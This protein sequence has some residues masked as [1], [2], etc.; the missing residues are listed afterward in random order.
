MN[1]IVKLANAIYSLGL[2]EEG[3][4]ILKLARKT[5]KS[6][7]D[8]AREIIF[9]IYDNIDPIKSYLLV[10]R[11][12]QR[13]FISYDVLKNIFAKHNLYI[14]E[15]SSN[16]EYIKNGLTIEI[17]LPMDEDK[18][19]ENLSLIGKNNLDKSKSRKWTLKIGGSAYISGQF[20][21]IEL[22]PTPDL[23]GEN[24]GSK[25]WFEIILNDFTSYTFLIH[26]ITHIIDGI[27]FGKTINQKNVSDSS[28]N[29]NQNYWN[30]RLEM[31]A[32]L[33]QV[34]TFLREQILIECPNLDAEEYLK[35]DKIKN[36]FFEKIILSLKEDDF[37]KFKDEIFKDHDLSLMLALEKIKSQNV[38]KKYT[39]RLFDMFNYLRRAFKLGDSSGRGSLSN[40]PNIEH[41]LND[42]EQE[43]EEEL[44]S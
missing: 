40:I 30:S 8:I 15:L 34:F 32:R 19:K 13:F 36:P 41:E 42:I 22:Y 25:N 4:L 3:S 21:R 24:D 37:I 12:H 33:M 2:Y 39:A 10:G 17:Y 35:S 27:R 7:S 18:Y 20:K 31:Q 28:G 6:Y 5:D 29:T 38:I 44:I 9:F 11:E 43:S 23:I 16:S 26:E 14:P 1:K